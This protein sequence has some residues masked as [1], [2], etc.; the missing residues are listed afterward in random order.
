MCSLCGVLGASDHWTEAVAR[1]GVFAPGADPVARRRERARRV[2]MANGILAHYGMNISDWHGTSF[3]LATA[4]GK[5]ELLDSLGH[6]WAV[7]EQLSA[8][9]CDPLDS[10]LLARL[11]AA[12]D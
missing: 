11:A 1:P 6:L 9:R 10:T 8:R 12:R 5:S 4:T 7:A 3:L 2:A